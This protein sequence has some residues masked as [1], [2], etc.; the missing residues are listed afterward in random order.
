MTTE[1]TTDQILDAAQDGTVSY[2]VAWDALGD[3]CP[4]REAARCEICE[5]LTRKEK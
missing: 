3:P 1:L 2:K 5:A 4:P